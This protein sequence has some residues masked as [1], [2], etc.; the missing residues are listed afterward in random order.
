MRREAPSES[1]WPQLVV[2]AA[3]LMCLVHVCS[4]EAAPVAVAFTEGSSHGYLMVT[5]ADGT[6]LA[7]GEFLQVVR[8]GRVESR[9]VFHF[10]DGSLYDEKVVYT[11]DTVFALQGYQL[12]QRGASF[13]DDVQVTIDRRAGRYE[14]RSRA[15]HEPAEV[16]TAG[17]LEMPTDVYNGMIGML[18][19]NLPKGKSETV[20]YL[21]FTPEPTLINLELLP[22]ADEPVRVGDLVKYATRYALKPQLNTVVHFF[23]RLLGRLPN[24][25]SYRF[26]V[27]NDVVPAFARFEGPLYLMGPAW[28]IE[29]VSPRLETSVAI[30]TG[31]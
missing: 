28:R 9:L 11:Q 22:E 7:Q 24:E 21:A 2:L 14:V 30:K 5:S 19:K 1:A 12:V 18:L 13:P 16:V 4:A 23:G 26:W 25:F 17:Q 8:G 6:G 15:N 10:R 27:L 3:V 20:R 29:M 31:G